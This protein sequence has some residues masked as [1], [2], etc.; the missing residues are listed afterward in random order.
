MNRL[1]VVRAAWSVS[2]ASVLCVSAGL[3]ISGCGGTTT[4][5]ADGSGSADDGGGPMV[6]TPVSSVPL[7]DTVN[8][9][10]LT[11]AVDV[12]RDEWGIPH[13]YGT[14]FADVAFAQGYT[15]ASDRLVLM[16][17]GRRQAE[18]SLAEL[19]GGLFATVIDSD[20]QMR[21][22]HLRLT[23]EQVWGQLKAS[24]DDNDKQ[25]V[26]GV[27]NYVAGVNAFM[28]DLKSG[29][30]YLAGR[31]HPAEVSRRRHRRLHG[32]PERSGAARRHPP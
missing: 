30:R 2:M 17:L 13:I 32:A 11:S 19:I 4:P 20:I 24:T 7:T 22:H 8:S 9:D 12:V 16:D 6:T 25:I 26:A 29:R 15:H 18:G 28:E 31:H 5:P 27:S 1:A 23:A 10:K 3:W 14:R 21:T